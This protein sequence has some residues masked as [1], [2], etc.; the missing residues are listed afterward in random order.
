MLLFFLLLEDACNFLLKILQLLRPFGNRLRWD[1]A[2]A[3]L[4]FPGS[5]LN[6]GL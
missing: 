5:M 1:M 2:V 3:N 4:V 6:S